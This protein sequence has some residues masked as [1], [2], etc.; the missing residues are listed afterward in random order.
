[1]LGARSESSTEKGKSDEIQPET[2]KTTGTTDDTS[3]PVLV[4]QSD[5]YGYHKRKIEIG[6]MGFYMDVFFRARPFAVTSLALI[7]LF[8]F[9]ALAQMLAWSSKESNKKIVKIENKIQ[10]RVEEEIEAYYEN[11][12]RENNDYGL[13]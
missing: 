2:T 3:E 13:G 4:A 6:S 5:N 9:V 10:Q 7:T 11:Q 1:M 12:E 8:A